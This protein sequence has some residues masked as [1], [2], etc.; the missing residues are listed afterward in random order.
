MLCLFIMGIPGR[1]WR[2]RFHD[3][4]NVILLQIVKILLVISA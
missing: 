2:R 1:K 4:F 3:R